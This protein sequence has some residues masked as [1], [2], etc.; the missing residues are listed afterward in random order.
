MENYQREFI[1]FA[2]DCK[3]LCFG[4]FTLKSGRSSPYFFNCGLFNTGAS[5]VQ[6]GRYY[7][8]AIQHA[9]LDYDMLFGPAYKGIPLA[10][11]T[12]IALAEQYNRDVPYCFN[13]KEVKYYGE[14]GVTFGAPLS[15]RV[16]IIVDVIS[17]GATIS[18][19]VDIIRARG[20]VPV[21]V[22]IALDR[23]ERGT[24]KLSA[25]HEVEA[26]HQMTVTSIITL[27]DLVAYLEEEPEMGERLQHVRDYRMQYGAA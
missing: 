1:R 21:G 14:G 19:S 7:A 10:S 24:G 27:D 4:N 16:L 2:F 20:A 12:A 6:L 23:Q 11:A 15:G 26:R 22:V 3:V 18:T 9:G 13:R 25:V 5:L 17:A 8:T